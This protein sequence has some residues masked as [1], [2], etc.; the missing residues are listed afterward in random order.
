MS[1]TL[2]LVTATMLVNCGNSSKDEGTVGTIEQIAP[3]QVAKTNQMNL[4]IHYMPW[5]VASATSGVW[6]HWT[7]SANALNNTNYASYYH[8]LIGPYA[9]SDEAVLDYQCLLMKYAGAD[10][11]MVDWYGTQQTSDYPVNEL[12][13]R[14]M[15]KAIEKAGLKFVIVYEDQTL[16]ALTDKTTQA[17]LD[18][19]YLSYNYFSSPNYVK[20]NN[21]PLLL[22]FGPQA[23]T[24]APEWTSTF[25]ILPT[26]PEFLV[27]TGK[28][29][30]CNNQDAT[31][32]QGEFSWVNPAPDY[33]NVSKF[34]TYVGGAMPGFKDHYKE[35]GVGTGYTTYDRENGNLFDRQLTAAKSAGLRWLQVSTWNDYGEGTTI[36]PTQEYGYQ[37]LVQLQKFT[38]VTYTQANLELIDRWYRVRVTKP[39]DARVTQA[40]IYLA[41]LQ[42]DKAKAFIENLEK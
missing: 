3:A 8:P 12:H 23:L 35:S 28:S 10:G 31:N 37:P 6:N 41:A 14:L 11:V 13:T 25:G 15:L 32:A 20:V 19:R 34:N 42:P 30:M 40:Y 16:N 21:K 7:M 1:T 9:S 2:L 39:N 38:G 18:M 5:F 29:Y 26:K 4:Y 24:T 17:R 22:C 33:S 36:E 27:L